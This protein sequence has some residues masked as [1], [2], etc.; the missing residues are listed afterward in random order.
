MAGKMTR[1]EKEAFKKRMAAG[2][3]KAARER[4]AA[5]KSNPKKRKPAKKRPA[6]KKAAKKKPASRPNTK[7][8]H[9]GAAKK[10]NPKKRRRNSESSIEEASQQFERFHGK[11]PSKILEYTQ[12][13]RY[14]EHY[15]ELGKL[16]ELRCW[17]DDDNPEFSFTS[18]GNCLVVCTPDGSNI[19]LLGGDQSIDLN[20]M[21]LSSDKDV[22]EIG[23]CMYISYRTVKG[24]HDFEPTTYWHEFGEED[25]IYP[26]LCYDRLNQRLFLASGNY[27]IRPEGIVN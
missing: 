1:A 22:V 2:R 12:A 10:S 18:F 8:V 27:R 16:I 5:K 15:A 25:D 9:R 4:G 13:M 21:G 11:P 26:I 24:F 6:A 3:R 7:H 19:Y 14:P 20:A 17:V 23:P